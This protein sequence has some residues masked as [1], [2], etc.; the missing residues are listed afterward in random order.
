MSVVADPFDFL[1]QWYPVS[2]I[3]D[4]DPG[5]PTPI[6]LL[7]RRYVIWKPADQ[8]AFR[9]FLDLCPHR[10]APLSE[11]RIDPAT[12]QLSCS[13][14]GWQFDADGL[15]RRIPQAEPPEPSKEQALHLCATALPCRQEQG[16]LWLWPDPDSA[17]QAAAS[18]LPLSAWNKPDADVNWSS[19][20]RDLPYDWRTLVENVADPAHV[21]FAHHGVQGKRENA[22]PLSFEM[23]R[24]DAEGFEATAGNRAFSI[25]T[26]IT[27]QPPCRLEY[28]FSFPGE[29]RMGLISYCLPVGPGRSRIVAQFPRDFALRV[30]KLIPRWWDHISNRNEVLDGDAL[31]LHQQERELER[32]QVL[33]SGASWK[34]AYRLPASADRLVIAFRRWVDRHG[35]PTW[36]TLFPGSGP[37]SHSL[38]GAAP[39]GDH[40]LDR[41]HQHTIHCASCRG[42]LKAIQRLQWSGGVVFVVGLAAA[43]LVSDSQRPTLGLALVLLALTGLAGAAALRFGLEPRFRYRPYDHTKR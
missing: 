32:R 25:G 35:A 36:D 18:P 33:D 2:P 31:M 39:S 34:T 42:A 3:E 41:Y 27:F 13:Y 43:A 28:A 8:P 5:R 11:G 26:R 37:V 19:V 40:L 38:S 17:E 24:E 22:G 14:H 29:R 23:L 16:L 9:I 12:G 15:C 10:L 20:V 6:E 1:H 21:A 7:G 30:Q 4:L